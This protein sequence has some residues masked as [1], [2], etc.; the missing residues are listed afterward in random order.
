MCLDNAASA[1]RMLPPTLH[2]YP[3]EWAL[4]PLQ[5][6]R[7]RIENQDGAVEG[8]MMM[9]MNPPTQTAHVQNLLRGT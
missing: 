1:L 5:Y 8:P 2:E 3:Q 9:L 7:I 4:N 6:R